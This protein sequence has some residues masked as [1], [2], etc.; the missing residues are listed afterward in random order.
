MTR[1]GVRDTRYQ[2]AQEVPEHPEQEPA[3]N[4]SEQVHFYKFV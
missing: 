2:G 4:D 3:R 1:F